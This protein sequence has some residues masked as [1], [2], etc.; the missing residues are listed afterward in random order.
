MQI[1][2]YVHAVECLMEA[3]YAGSSTYWYNPSTG[4][5]IAVDDHGSAVQER[6]HLFDIDLDIEQTMIDAFCD[7]DDGV[8][9]E[10]AVLP[11]ELTIG[12]RKGNW[13]EDDAWEQLAMNRGWV[14]V[15]EGGSNWKGYV[16][17]ATA[18]AIQAAIHYILKNGNIGLG[19]ELEISRPQNQIFTTMSDITLKRFVK[20]G[21]NRAEM[22]M[23]QNK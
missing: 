17:A 1:R 2:D 15:G 13:Y 23:S 14:R 12:W 22:F 8:C 11:S 21:P 4:E 5:R 9:D 18:E 19:M 7:H 3:A 10:D 6:P 20:A 16:S